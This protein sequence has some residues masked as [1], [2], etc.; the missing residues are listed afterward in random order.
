MSTQNT[1]KVNVTVTTKDG[2]QYT[3]ERTISSEVLG[4]AF[5]VMNWQRSQIEGDPNVVKTEI[6]SK[7]TK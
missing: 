6:W 2:Q 1:S 7:V 3:E 4:D 5:A